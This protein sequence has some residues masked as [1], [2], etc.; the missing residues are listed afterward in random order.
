MSTLT[1]KTSPLRSWELA[2]PNDMVH[3][4]SSPAYLADKGSGGVDALTVNAVHQLGERQGNL[5]HK[6]AL[7]SV[8][9]AHLK[10]HNPLLPLQKITGD[11]AAAHALPPPGISANLAGK[12]LLA[13]HDS[14]SYE[15]DVTRTPPTAIDACACTGMFG[16]SIMLRAPRNP[17]CSQHIGCPESSLE[18]PDCPNRVDMLHAYVRWAR[19]RPHPQSQGR[20]FALVEEKLRLRIV[21]CVIPDLIQT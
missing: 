19:G 9:M 1:S 17:A 16:G 18:V 21:F 13:G 15:T 8:V 5:A 2:W 11:H 6:L 20:R 3:S 10:R 4:L 14:L 12:T 7:A